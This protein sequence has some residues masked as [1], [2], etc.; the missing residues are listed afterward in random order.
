MKFQPTEDRILVKKI[1]AKESLIGGIIIPGSA[2]ARGPEQAVVIAVGPGRY[3]AGQLIPHN[4][5]VGDKVMFMGGVE[6][7]VENEDY[8]LMRPESI[9][10]KVI[11]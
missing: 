6:M 5:N 7:K 9:F 2:S 11:E 4:I 8:I 10:G 3:E 1:D